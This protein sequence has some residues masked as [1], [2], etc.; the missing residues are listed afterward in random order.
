M[1]RWRSDEALRIYARLNDVEY[2]TWLDVAATATISGTR[3]ANLP[4]VVGT[5]AEAA[6]REQRDWLRA[7]VGADVEAVAP[8]DRPV[9]DCDLIVGQLADG[10]RALTTAAA[11]A[12]AED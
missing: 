2:A 10:V 7:V 4:P 3:A 6:A 5:A 9:T 8:A 12:D 11:N 1:L